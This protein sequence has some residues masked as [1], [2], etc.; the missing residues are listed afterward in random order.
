MLIN[1]E[2]KEQRMQHN[3][4]MLDIPVQLQNGKLP[5]K[6]LIIKLFYYE[7][8]TITA[9]GVIEPRYIA[10]TSEG[11][12]PVARLSEEQWQPR[13]VI[14]KLGEEVLSDEKNTFK[15]G[16]IVWVD[17][18]TTANHSQFL[19]NRESPVDIPQG[20]IKVPTFGVEF[21]EGTYE[22]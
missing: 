1:E 22:N 20:Y 13:G 6:N 10:E 16:D 18:R 2:I 4:N 12:R 5:G 14:V 19:V 17:H 11:G 8:E 9:S 21:I 15:V 7:A 3:K